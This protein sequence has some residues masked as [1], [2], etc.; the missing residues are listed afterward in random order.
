MTK[1]APHPSLPAVEAVEPLFNAEALRDGVAALGRRLAQELGDEDPLLVGLLGGSLIFLADLVR[2]VE[3]P[4]RFELIHV[5]YSSASDVPAEPPT[6]TAR[7]EGFD[8][9]V[10]S[11]HY[12][13]PVE[14]AG[15]SVV[16]VKD[17][18]SSGVTEPYLAQQLR[19][20]GARE[21]R[22]AAL[23]DLPDE[24]KT[25]FELHYSVFQL[26]HP[27]DARGRGLLVGYGLKHE[28]RFGHLPFVGLLPEGA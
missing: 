17:V 10:L 8:G 27:R 26:R 9:G 2:A 12:P 1:T 28:G 18:V 22:F 23:I 3:R 21:V 6:D 24:R 11:I 13:L 19:D 5:G 16:V 14:V 15:Q 25:E 4:V 20:H 7:E